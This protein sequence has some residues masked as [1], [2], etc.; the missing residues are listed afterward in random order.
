[1]RTGLATL[2][3]TTDRLETVGDPAY[4]HVVAYGRRDVVA[5]GLQQA[6]DVDQHPP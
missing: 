3:P 5:S 6:A 4:L 2:F 1:V